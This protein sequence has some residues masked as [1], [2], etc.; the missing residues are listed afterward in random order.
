MKNENYWGR[1]SILDT[2]TFKVIPEGGTRVAELKTGN[3]QIIEPVQPNEVQE[4]NGSDNGTVD[5]KISS[6]LNYLRL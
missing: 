6:S 2:V 3:A 5:E 1:S 4:I